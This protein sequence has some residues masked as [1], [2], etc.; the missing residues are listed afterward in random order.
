MLSLPSLAATCKASCPNCIQGWR[1][2]HYHLQTHYYNYQHTL[3]YIFYSSLK[4]HLY[5]RR[6][7]YTSPNTYMYVY[8][9]WD[10]LCSFLINHTT[11]QLHSLRNIWV[12]EELTF[13][14]RTSHYTTT[15]HT[16]PLTS[17]RF[18]LWLLPFSLVLLSPRQQAHSSCDYGTIMSVD[19]CRQVLQSNEN[20]NVKILLCKHVFSRLTCS[21]NMLHINLSLPWSHDLYCNWQK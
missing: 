15:P 1:N 4:Y 21:T 20:G 2:V 11:Q 16:S 13:R 9:P 12:E 5:I 17:T 19:T 7:K 14:E 6:G 18:D 10:Y 3:Q 8:D